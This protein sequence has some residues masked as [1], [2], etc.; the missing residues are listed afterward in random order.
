MTFRK[1]KL[2]H[3]RPGWPLLKHDALITKTRVMS[4]ITELTPRKKTGRGKKSLPPSVVCIW[5]SSSLLWD[6]VCE[7]RKSTVKPPFFSGEES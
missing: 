2:I 4:A 3:K 1:S 6:R 7:Y 5:F